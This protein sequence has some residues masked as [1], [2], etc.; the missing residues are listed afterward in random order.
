MG[1]EFFYVQPAQKKQQRLDSLSAAFEKLSLQGQTY[2]RNLYVTRLPANYGKEEVAELFSQFGKVISI[3]VGKDSIT[4]EDKNWAYVCFSSANEARNAIEKGNEI[5]INNQKINISYFKNKSERDHETIDVVRQ[6]LM[7]SSY[8]LKKPEAMRFNL[9]RKPFDKK[10]MGGDL[11]GLVL[12]LAPTFSPQWKN[13]GIKDNEEFA[14]R[15][16]GLLLKRPSAD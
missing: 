3:V 2:K 9:T 4:T 7:R 1:P 6:P 14:S 12:S 15:I 13:L 11:Y 8:I 10:Q 5:H 16:T